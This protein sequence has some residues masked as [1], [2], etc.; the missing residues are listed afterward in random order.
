[1]RCGSCKEDNPTG[2]KFC[3]H[4]GAP[5]RV[6]AVETAE[7]RQ[8]TVLFCDLVGSTSLS[9]QLDPEDLREV[10]GTYQ[11]VC[12][13]AIRR[14]E[15]HI[16]Q[17]L[18]DGVLVY[19]G[20]PSAHED[21]DRRAVRTALEIIEDLA[22]V[23]RRY[24]N[25][26]GITLNVRLG[27]HT[28]PVVVG[29]VGGGERREQLAVGMTPNLAARVQNLAAPG[30]VVISEVTH[31]M[32][33]GYFDFSGLGVHEVKGLVRPVTLYR[34]LR[35]S[36]AENRLDVQRRIGLTPLTGRDKE[37]AHLGSVWDALPGS[38][39]QTVLIEGEPGIGKSRITD[40]FREI[41]RQQSGILMEC[42]CTPYAQSTALYPIVGMVER[43]LGFTRESS[44]AEKRINLERRL[45]LR[46]VLT[47]ETAALMMGLLSIPVNGPDPLTTY[48]PQKRRERTLET[49]LSWLIAVAHEGPTLWVLEDIH[50]VDP[51]TQDFLSSV[52]KINASV[53][54]LVVLTTRPGFTAP[55]T[56]GSRFSKIGLS[57]L[58]PGETTF[59]AL[60][61]AQGKSIPEEVLRQIIARA[62]GVPLFVEE[63]TK[64][65]LEMGVLIELEDRFELAGDFPADLIPT[66]LQGSLVARLDRL[67]PAKAVAQ[68]A[69]TIGR[70]FSFALLSA[71]SQ[72]EEPEVRSGLS[73]LIGAELLSRMD[74][75][76]DETYL[77]K[78]AL[79]R[80]AAY[81]SLLRKSRRGLHEKIA[82][83]LVDRFP[84]TVRRNPELVAEHFTAA[85]QAEPAVKWWLHAGQR[86]VGRGANHEAIS[87]LHRGLK[88]A[89]NLPATIQPHKELE[90]LS[91]LMPALIGTEGW[92]SPEL[93]RNYERAAEL[94]EIVGDTPLRLI[95]LS[96]QMGYHFVSGRIRTAVGLAYQVREMAE[97]IGDPSLRVIGNQLVSGVHM[98][99]A[100]FPL[101][102]EYAD[103]GLAFLD[104]D[105]ERVLGPLM[106]MCPSVGIMA[107]VSLAHWMMGFPEKAQEVSRGALH[108]A[109][110][111][112]LSPS[113]GFALTNRLQTYYSIN[114]TESMSAAA[115]EA[116]RV[117]SQ[118]RLGYFSPIVKIY[119]EWAL[120]KRGESTDAPSKIQA[121]IEE[122][123]AGGNGIQLVSYY[124]IL[125]MVEWEAG[126]WD[127]A[128]RTLESTM[129]LAKQWGEGLYEPELY[130]RKG[131]FLAAEA[132]GRAGRPIA[133]GDREARLAE[134][135]RYI[136]ESIEIARRQ[137][138]KMLELRALVSLCRLRTECGV[139]APERES[140]AALLATFT[141]GF[142]SVDWREAQAVLDVPA[143]A[144]N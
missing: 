86:S 78:H 117:L 129:D 11:S 36:G 47:D 131:E 2:T 76:P 55:W 127:A 6:A 3:G 30:T 141:E 62:D 14:H 100:Q 13:T 91:A 48:S 32:V 126:E 106:G 82:E 121:A 44:D 25:E 27:I 118:E 75:V 20:Y 135:E 139:I 109:E 54:L 39:G 52:I 69:A 72:S 61:V 53:P 29:E 58:G 38:G 19:F 5:L 79:V 114:N 84:E 24:Q 115:D 60:S 112:G 65:I 120:W 46:G 34:V 102:V 74:E 9:E 104:L 108:L 77:F 101:S 113:I 123:K 143:E 136:I 49:L 57:R 130:R 51:S 122:Y 63:I 133:A 71:V 92:A 28:G 95:L 98:Y 12:E 67:G 97:A 105:R 70:E 128:F 144:P 66:T 1:M 107:N 110:R 50:W 22:I 23:S 89:V 80:D 56:Q 7:L 83:T 88:L 124:N 137:S 132:M 103:R 15:G 43:I 87:H 37:L 45:A 90:L 40:S 59:M 8:L 96:G 16:A 93:G 94:I 17:Y 134:A 35:E 64:T 73:R 81:Q 138:A 116:Q 33:R 41:V 31:A 18:G 21:D 111:I 10:T 119:R 142:D 26:R 85:E 4:C 99:G 140:L 42:Y 68:V 125:A